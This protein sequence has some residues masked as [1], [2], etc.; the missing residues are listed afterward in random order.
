M[1]FQRRPRTFGR[2]CRTLLVVRSAWRTLIAVA[3]IMGLMLADAASS[4]RTGGCRWRQS[5][6][7]VEPVSKYMRR[8]EQASR[9][10]GGRSARGVSTARHEFTGRAPFVKIELLGGTTNKQPATGEPLAGCWSC[11]DSVGGAD[12]PRLA[13]VDPVALR[14]VMT[15]SVYAYAQAMVATDIARKG[16]AKPAGDGGGRRGPWRA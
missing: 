8:C 7:G 6:S 4:S 13:G 16:H 9:M 15:N 3:P 14:A 10:Q 11:C 2:P 12:G 5:T 1:A